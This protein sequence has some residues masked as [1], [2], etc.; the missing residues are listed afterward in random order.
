MEKANFWNEKI[1]KN[2][3][4]INSP[5]AR[6]IRILCELTAPKARFEQK[7]VENTI[8]FF[9]SARSICSEDAE[10]NLEE[11][12]QKSGSPDQVRKAEATLKLSKY[13][14]ASVELAKKLSQWSMGI[15]EKKN[16]F[17][18]CSGGG[19]G[20]MEAANLG[21]SKAEHASI[22]LNISLPFEQE[23]NPYQSPDLSFEFHY[24]FIRKFWFAYLAKALIVFPG[25]FGT[26][27]ELFEVLTLIQ[28]GKIT[29]TIPIVLFGKEFW[30]DF[31]NFDKL[32]KWGVIS[33]KDLGLF[34]I[35]D[36][37][38]EAYEYL[39]DTLTKEYL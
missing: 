10:K 2:L 16:R 36:N 11:L 34:K 24:F 14:D 37:V 13:Y 9:G 7:D 29:K 23:P 3:E 18:V 6:Q 12:V 19:P 8:V 17:F 27:D 38:D 20:M 22:G 31:L 28:T 4:F 1:Y 33:E 26:M 25:G 21:A 15:K 35:Y 5:E 30:N 32:I 39:K